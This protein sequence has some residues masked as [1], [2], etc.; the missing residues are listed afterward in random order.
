MIVCHPANCI[1]PVHYEIRAYVH[2]E[3]TSSDPYIF[4]D[5]ISCVPFWCVSFYCNPCLTN[6]ILLP[7]AL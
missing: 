6:V 7:P 4:D 1:V 2:M 5:S 3:T